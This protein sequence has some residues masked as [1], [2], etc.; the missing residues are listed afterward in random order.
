MT[1]IVPLWALYILGGIGILVA[2]VLMILGV[3]FLWV[4]RKGFNISW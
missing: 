1:I 3:M 4:F 2:L